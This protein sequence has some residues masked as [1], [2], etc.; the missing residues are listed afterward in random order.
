[1]LKRLSF[2]LLAIQLV[3]S[4]FRKWS[5]RGVLK[6]SV[7]NMCSKFTEEHPCRS[8]IS[9]KFLCILDGGNL[10]CRL[11]MQ[12]ILPWSKARSALFLSKSTRQKKF[13]N[14]NQASKLYT[15]F[16]SNIL[17]ANIKEETVTEKRGWQ[18]KSKFYAE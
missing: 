16:S 17:T 9:L 14:L 15:W 8:V 12:F 13:N 1:M 2:L 18:N 5:S 11:H 4:G 6:K 7:L 10:Y 3:K